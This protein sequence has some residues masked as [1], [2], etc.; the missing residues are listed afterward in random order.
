MNLG[1]QQKKLVRIIGIVAV[2]I[3]IVLG[4]LYATSLWAS[5]GIPQRFVDARKNAAL[6]SSDIVRLANETN[7][8]IAQINVLEIKGKKSDALALIQDARTS[9]G[10][11]YT[12]AFELSQNLKTLAESLGD[13]H[14]PG[15][16]RIAYE[17]I[18]I[19]LSLV[20]EF[21]SYTQALNTFLGNLT[22]L[23]L[24]NTIQNQNIVRT[25]ISAVNEKTS[26]INN[27]NSQ[28]TEKMK[29]FDSS[30]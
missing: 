25:D 23:I 3:L 2:V 4:I 22:T 30:F 26:S 19:E 14:S 7:D 17:A 9:N 24:D 12:K 28:F 11:A 18:A 20:S 16:Q 1:N 27:L 15:E 8:K 6:V 13:I 21:I 5:R 10:A 29:T